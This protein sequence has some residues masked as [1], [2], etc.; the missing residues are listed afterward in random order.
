MPPIIFRIAAHFVVATCQ[1]VLCP[2]HPLHPTILPPLLGQ[3]VRYPL[4]LRIGFP[5][6]PLDEPSMV[7]VAPVP[8]LCAS[9]PRLSD[10]TTLVLPPR[11][12]MT[13]TSMTPMLGVISMESKVFRRSLN[14]IAGV[15]LRLPVLFSFLL[16]SHD[17][18]LR[19]HWSSVRSLPVAPFIPNIPCI[20]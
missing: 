14:V 8:P 20:T 9:T 16:H 11:V 10:D 3:F 17:S 12:L 1:P 7:L 15:M 2:P 5:L 19:F 13:T 6:P 4:H 18:F